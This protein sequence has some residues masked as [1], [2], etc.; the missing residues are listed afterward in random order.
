[1]GSAAVLAHLLRVLPRS[2][3]SEFYQPD[4]RKGS[5]QRFK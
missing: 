4:F 1:M 2:G 3:G 5:R